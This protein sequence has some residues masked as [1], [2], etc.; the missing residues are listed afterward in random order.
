[1]TETNGASNAPEPHSVAD[2]DL[3]V[4]RRWR[5]FEAL[6]RQ[7]A[8]FADMYR[9]GINALNERPLTPGAIIVAGHCFRDLANGLPDV[10]TDVG[11]I[12]SYADT[13]TP[14]RELTRVWEIHEGHLGPMQSAIQSDAG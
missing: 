11:E 2:G 13:S 10:M 6:G 7:N 3:W 9:R 14:A 4:G 8:L 12:P 5:L 1:M